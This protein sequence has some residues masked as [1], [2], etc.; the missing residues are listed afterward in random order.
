[1]KRAL[2]I[3]GQSI[4]LFLSALA[5]MLFLRRLLPALHVVHVISQQNFLR[6]QY[7]FDWL[8]SVSLLYGIFL[9]I[10]LVTRRIRTSWI[11]STVAFVLTIL[12]IVVFTKI[13]FKDVNLLYGND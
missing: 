6:R 2:S 5:G 9:L 3:L 8:L 1:M 13:G 10:G 12:V 11:S 7:E 4:L